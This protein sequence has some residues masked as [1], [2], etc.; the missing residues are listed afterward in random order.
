MQ[1]RHVDAIDRS[2][3]EVLAGE[4]R[5]S[6]QDLGRRVGMSPTATADR[7]R[8]LER[9][10][11]IRGYRAV[12]DPEPFGLSLEASIDVR[13]ASNADRERFAQALRDH[14][15][16]LEAVHVTGDYDYVVRVRCTGSRHLDDLL[17]VLKNEGGVADTRTRLL[18]HRIDG[19]GEGIF[20]TD[21][22]VV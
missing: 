8:R 11:V 5:M 3:L 4:G 19:L 2:I 9:D 20:D 7:V 1:D 6:F 16:V 22:G 14:G 21:A 13:L 15:T 17:H 18:L 10:G 12:I